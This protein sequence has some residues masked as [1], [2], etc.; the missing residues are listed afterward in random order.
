M[1]VILDSL[2]S[3]RFNTYIG[4]RGERSGTGLRWGLL[5]LP[6]TDRAL[7]EK[8]DRNQ[9]IFWF[10]HCVIHAIHLS[11][12]RERIWARIFCWGFIISALTIQTYFIVREDFFLVSTQEQNTAVDGWNEQIS[13][14]TAECDQLKDSLQEVTKVLVSALSVVAFF[15][16]QTTVPV[17]KWSGSFKN[18]KCQLQLRKQTLLYLIP[19]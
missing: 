11:Q 17:R 3:P 14:L 9:S 10:V 2:D 12:A 7:R 16:L 15:N 4:W 6:Y 19:V 8:G 1:Q 5:K 13:Q 18:G